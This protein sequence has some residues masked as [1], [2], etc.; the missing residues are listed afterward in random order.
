MSVFILGSAFTRNLSTSRA[1]CLIQKWRQEKGLPLNP[2]T[3]GVL[4]DKPDY[5]FLDGRP[6][7]LGVRQKNRIIKQQEIAAK[8]LQL[9]GEIDFAVERHKQN[10]QL[11]KQQV[12]TILKNKLKPKGKALL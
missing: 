8:I 4:T 5:T 11:E 2:N 12:E 3:S 6:T 7:P 1:T 9:S 10:L